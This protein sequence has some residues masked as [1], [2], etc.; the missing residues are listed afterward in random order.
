MTADRDFRKVNSEPLFLS[1]ICITEGREPTGNISP[2]CEFS[3]TNHERFLEFRAIQS[4]M[5]VLKSTGILTDL[6]TSRL[7]LFTSH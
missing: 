5:S 1:L 3:R 6:V 2:N 4:F 7:I